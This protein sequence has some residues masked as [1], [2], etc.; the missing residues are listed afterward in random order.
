MDE[1]GRPPRARE[2]LRLSAFLVVDNNMIRSF[3]LVVL[4]RSRYVACKVD[5]IRWTRHSR[6]IEAVRY[7]ERCLGGRGIDPRVSPVA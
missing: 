3:N 1:N 7:F 6:L 2:E 5:R 4:V